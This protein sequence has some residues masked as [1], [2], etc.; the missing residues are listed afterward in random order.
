MLAESPILEPLAQFGLAGFM[1]AMWL[2][3]RHTSRKREEQIDDA[4]A[5]IVAD[6]VLVDELIAVVRANAE[7]M[8]RLSTTQEQL[9]A[10]LRKEAK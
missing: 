6:R 1:G 2:W 8:A 9:I 4:H 3:E 10:S 5:R 7:A